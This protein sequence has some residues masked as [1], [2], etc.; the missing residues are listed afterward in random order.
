LIE[1]SLQWVFLAP[2][3]KDDSGRKGLLYCINYNYDGEV[4]ESDTFIV[5]ATVADMFFLIR[6]VNR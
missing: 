3:E 1:I 4:W 6:D 2:A 5:S